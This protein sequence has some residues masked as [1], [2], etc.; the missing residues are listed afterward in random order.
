MKKSWYILLAL[1]TVAVIVLAAGCSQAPEK[2]DEPGSS[3]IIESESVPEKSDE[4]GSSAIIESESVP[5][6]GDESDAPISEPETGLHFKTGTWE[7]SSGTNYVFYEDGK[8]GKT[9]NVDRGIGLGFEYELD[10]DGSGVFHMGSVDDMTKVTVEFIDGGDDA[11]AINWEDGS[12]TVLMFVSEDTSDDFSYNY[13]MGQI[14][15]E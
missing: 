3:A 5:E 13:K 10:A 7:T 2:G 11:A 1:V 14:T 15:R 9:V 12:R 8:G 6:K 4:S